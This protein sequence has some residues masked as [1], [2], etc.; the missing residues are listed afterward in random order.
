MV[1]SAID[2]NVAE[3]S[4]LVAVVAP[5]TTVTVIDPGN[6][7]VVVSAASCLKNI[8]KSP[9]KNP[10]LAVPLTFSLAPGQSVVVQLHVK[11]VL[12]LHAK[13]PI[14]SG[15]CIYLVKCLKGG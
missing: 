10:T 3:P 14:I 7:D 1:V 11:G 13:D 5:R 12:L 15:I 8:P 2:K 9:G 6:E 4:M